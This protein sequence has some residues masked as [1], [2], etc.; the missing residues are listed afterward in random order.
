M[1]P[2]ERLHGSN[3]IQLP[4]DWNHS[5]ELVPRGHP[6]LMFVPFYKKPLGVAMLWVWIHNYCGVVLPCTLSSSGTR[7]NEVHTS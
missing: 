1:V 6:S 5:N 7:E 4:A 2:L 3:T